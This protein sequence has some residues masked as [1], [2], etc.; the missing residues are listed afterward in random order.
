M[1]MCA[2]AQTI[3]SELQM[4]QTD[5]TIINFSLRLNFAAVQHWTAVTLGT[6]LDNFCT[7]QMFF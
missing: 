3:N 5:D 4:R 7:W 1:C 6:T 2:H